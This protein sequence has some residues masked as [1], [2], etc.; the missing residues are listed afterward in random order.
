MTPETTSLGTIDEGARRQ[1]ESAWGA[2]QP[3]PIEPFL[4]TEDH[5]HY[6]ATLEE[7]VHIDLEMRWQSSQR[8][9]AN[10]GSTLVQPPLVEAY[11][12]RFPH[13]NQPA[14]VRRLLHQERR[15]RHRCGHR[16]SPTEYQERFPALDLQSLQGE[17]LPEDT[18]GS[19]PSLPVIPGY[20]ILR[21]LGRGGMGVV[22]QARQVGL[23]RLVALKVILAG[24][25]A[26]PAELARFRHEAEAVARLQYPHIVQVFEVGEQAGAPY[27]SLEFV[28]GGT[29]AQ[30]LAGTPQPPQLA[31]QLTET[32]ARAISCA[33]QHG[34]VHRDLTP[35][36]VLLTAEGTAKITDFGLAKRLEGGA[37]QTRTG[38]VMGT[39]SYMAPEQ[40]AGKSKRIGPAVDIYGL[41][42]ILYELL[43]GRPPFRGETVWDTVVQVLSTEPVPPRRLQPK[44]PRDLETICLK[45]LEKEPTKRYVSAEAL[46]AE[47]RRFLNHEPIQARPVGPFARLGRW[48]RRNHFLAAASGLALAALMAA[49]A[50][51]LS[52]GLYQSQAAADLG[53]ALEKA[54]T[55]RRQAETLSAR[56]AFEQGLTLCEQKDAARGMLWLARSLELATKAGDADLQKSIRTHLAGWYRQLI[57]LSNRLEHPDVITG[58]TLSPD[59][60]TL[61]VRG[62]STVRLRDAATGKPIGKVLRHADEILDAVFSP[63]GKTVATASKDKTARLWDAA[64]G[65]PRGEP[66]P[67]HGPVTS[68]AFSPDSK[69]LLTGSADKTAQ[70]WDVA[71]GRPK[72]KPLPH[73]AGVEAVAFSPKGQAIL[74]RGGEKA[75]LWEPTTGKPI[76]PLL[77]KSAA[78]SPDGKRLVTNEGKVFDTATGQ[79]AFT[80]KTDKGPIKRELMERKFDEVV[81]SPSGRVI[82]TN[83]N[84]TT[85]FW[86]AAT[87]EPIDEPLRHL[88]LS[89]RGHVVFRPRPYSDTL[90]TVGGNQ[91]W[92]WDRTFLPFRLHGELRHQGDITFGAFSPDGRM[93]LT[94]SEDSEARLWDADTAAPLGEPLRH[95]GQVRAAAFGPDGETVWTCSSKE[96]RLW[97]RATKE[98]RGE[99]LQHPGDVFA[100]A[101]SPDGKKI[102]TGSP[103]ATAQLW[104][105]ATGRAIGRPLKH[106][107]PVQS[108]AFSRDGLRMVTAWSRKDDKGKKWEGEA[109]IWDAATLR[110]IG[111]PVPHSSTINT[112]AYSPDGKILHTSCSPSSKAKTVAL[113]PDGKILLAGSVDKMARLWDTATAKVL[114][115]PLV[116]AR[117]IDT[118]AF[119]PDGQGFQGIRV[120]VP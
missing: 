94:V 101:Y 107:G 17:S 3:A 61:M 84:W 73:P 92:L 31:A 112:V 72:G 58:L 6:L 9:A 65:L 103:E 79:M 5:P 109:R 50:L 13:L 81:F 113:S 1:F 37:G 85:E 55:Q 46:A 110:P 66:L 59:G 62:G 43:T 33:H 18:D 25:H 14:I 4:P 117:E 36:N 100:V 11:L 67:H 7:L 115:K 69:T 22:Y 76:G 53:D 64:T 8:P 40:A 10:Q 91:A 21:V 119:T 19:A 75:R 48:C 87:G 116:H 97:K 38:E 34:I 88:S 29:L 102:L 24:S 105:S 74:V 32:L 80:L 44:V 120:G 16:P 52:F 108:V 71:T 42:A 49:F 27:F 26:G 77:H 99:I 78:F 86:D 23:N 114:G 2:G 95:Q 82:V 68:A 118:V 12:A 104:D 20:E 28:G 39:P 30:K 70:L 93:V 35:A 15:V 83:G 51:A 60:R 63:D 106:P 90:L 41:G 54:Q 56:L 45:C 98:L 57:P 96:A 47:L 89:G 111:K